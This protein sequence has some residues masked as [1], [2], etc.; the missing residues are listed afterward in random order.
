MNVTFVIVVVMMVLV[1]SVG[2]DSNS[3]ECAKENVF[4]MHLHFS[5]FYEHTV[6]RPL[7]PKGSL[8]AFQEVYRMRHPYDFLYEVVGSKLIQQWYSVWKKCVK[9]STDVDLESEF[10][11]YLED[12]AFSWFT[13]AYFIYEQRHS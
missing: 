2:A 8:Q 6:E 4:D 9:K 5:I 11:E 7:Y 13:A 10:N 3:L 1:A 12:V